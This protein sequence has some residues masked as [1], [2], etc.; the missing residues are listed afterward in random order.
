MT[1]LENISLRI[2]HG[3]KQL[4]EISSMFEKLEPLR[5]NGTVVKRSTAVGEYG[6][7]DHVRP[8]FPISKAA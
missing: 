1:C 2:R 4:I 5:F 6:T 7:I 3:S 8:Q